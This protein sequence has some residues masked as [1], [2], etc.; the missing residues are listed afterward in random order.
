MAENTGWIQP[1]A[2]ATLIWYDGVA[3]TPS[4]RVYQVAGPVLEAPLDSPYF[5]LAHVDRGDF[6]SRLY[7]S[8]VS[9][10]EL[11]DFLAGC[12]VA[13]GGLSPE[14]EFV[15]ARNEAALL[16]LLDTW[17]HQ[18]AG[19]PLIFL[20]DI[21]AFLLNDVAL[22]VTS[23]SHAAVQREP[24]RFAAAWVCEECGQ[25]DDQAVFLWTVHAR[26]AIQVRLAIQAT[27]GV[28][29]CWL[30]PFRIQKESR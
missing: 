19:E 26:R 21:N 29:T 4:G 28:W 11:R 9:L 20:A 13:E 17:V 18:P 3:E 10:A 27:A 5:L 7:E 23:E 30:H 8:K 12:R 6:A 14:R 25:A 15:A 2:A 22:F 24:E 16:P 1:G